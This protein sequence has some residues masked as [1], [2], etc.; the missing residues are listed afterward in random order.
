MSFLNVAGRAPF[1][2]QLHTERCSH[3]HAHTFT[4]T[5]AGS[6]GPRAAGRAGPA[7]GLLLPRPGP[8]AGHL[9]SLPFLPSAALARQTG[10]KIQGHGEDLGSREGG[11]GRR[12]PSAPPRQTR[13]D[14]EGTAGPCSRHGRTWRGRQGHAADL[15]GHGGD[16]REE[17]TWQEQAWSCQ[18]RP[19]LE[20]AVNS[21]YSGTQQVLNRGS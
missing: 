11:P 12:S 13:Q 17:Q 19:S 14:E 7:H 1:T 15:A 10:Q 4:H 21:S 18:L 2:S 3:I 8:A 9:Q 6:P 20:P 16:S 5:R